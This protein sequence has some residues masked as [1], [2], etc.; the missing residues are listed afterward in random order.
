MLGQ[1]YHAE[2]QRGRRFYRHSMFYSYGQVDMLLKQA[3]FSIAEVISTLFQDPR[4]VN[5]VELP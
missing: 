1:F 4:E 3:G 2:K 5:Y